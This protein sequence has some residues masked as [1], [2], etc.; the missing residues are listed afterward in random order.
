L[1]KSKNKSLNNGGEKP[2]IIAIGASAG[3]L[4]ALQDLLSNF[5]TPKKPFSVIIAQHVSP[6]HKSMLVQLLRRETNLEVEEATNGSE[7]KSGFVYITPPDNDISVTN[8]KIY[9]SKPANSVGPKPSVDIL[10]KSL[11]EQDAN[12]VIGIILSGTGTDGAHGVE[13]LKKAGAYILVQDPSTAKYDGMPATSIL[14]DSVDVILHPLKMGNAINR[15]ISNPEEARLALQADL[16]NIAGTQK[17]LWLLGKHTGTDFSNYKSA[18]INRRLQRRI[19]ILGLKD[20][21]E[22]TRYIDETPGELD[23]M[24]NSILIGVTTFFRD[25]DAFEALEEVL[26]KLLNSKPTTEPFRIWIPGC[27]TGEE[28][29]SIAIL[30]TKLTQNRPVQRDIQIFATDIDEKAIAKARKGIYSIDSV[31]ELSNEILD[32]YFIKQDE[33]FELQKSIRSMVL[34]SKHDLTSNPPFLKLDLITCRNLL[35]YFNTTLQQQVIPLFHYALNAE[36]YLLLGKSESIGHFNDLFVA[37]DSKVKLFQRK[38]GGSLNAVKFSGFKAVKQTVPRY[39]KKPKSDYTVADMVKETLFNT[40]EHPYVIIDEEGDIREISGDVRLFLSLSP[41]SIQVNLL[42]M[43]NKELQLELRSVVTTAIRKRETVRSSIRKFDLFGKEYFVRFHTK[44]LL[45]TKDSEILFMVIFERLDIDEFITKGV[46]QDTGEVIDSKVIELEHELATTKEHLQTYIEEIE[47]SNEE[48]QSLNEELQS[49]N[50]EF[51]STNEELETTNEELQSTNEEIQIAY[52]ELK[53]INEELERSE[54][55]LESRERNLKA[56][57]NNTLQAFV[58]IDD[59]YKVVLQNELA[60]Q[61]GKRLGVSQ[62]RPGLSVFDLASNSNMEK[63]IS[64]IKRA[65][66]GETIHDERKEVGP[67]GESIWLEYNLTP[68]FDSENKVVLVSLGLIDISE[69]K[70]FALKL[71]STEK[72]LHSVFDAAT[73]GICITDEKG[74][75]VDVNSEYCRIYGY[76]RGELIGHHFNMVVPPE[77]R[78]SLKELHDNFIAGASE[79]AAEWT[80]QRKDGSLIDIYASARLLVYEDGSRYKVTSVRDISE[81]KKYHNLLTET[82]ETAHV[83]GWEYDVFTKELTWTEEI[84]KIFEVSENSNADFEL[85]FNFFAFEAKSA[86]QEAVQVS[87]QKGDAF[88]LE[89]FGETSGGRPVWT[90]ITCKPIRVHNKT[91]KLFGTIQDVTSRKVND[92]QLFESEQKYRAAF[93]NSLL[94]F[95]VTNPDGTI[96]DANPA[97]CD[98]FGYSLDE[99]KALGR[100]GIIDGETPGLRSMLEDRLSH[101]KVRGELICIRKTGEK[102]PVEFTSALYKAADGQMHAT[103]LMHNISDR[104]NREQHLKLL[105]SVLTNTD[106]A[107]LITEA[108]PFSEPG[109]RIIYVNEAFTRMTGYTSDEV[110]GKTPRILQGPNTDKEALSKLSKALR[111]WESCE[112]ETINYKKNGEEFWINF[113][114]TPVA[115]EAGWYTH[116]FAIERDV[117]AQKNKEIERKLLSD[118]IVAMNTEGSLKESL[119]AALKCFTSIGEFELFEVWT[120]NRDSKHINLAARYG[121]TSAFKQFYEL[122]SEDIAMEFGQGLPGSVWKTRKMIYWD[123]ISQRKSFT[124]HKAAAKAGLK[125][126]YGFPLIQN[127]DVVGVL[128]LGLTEVV[129]EH[130]YYVPMLNEIAEH[131]A[132]EIRRKQLDEELERIFSFAPDVIC[133]AGMDGYFKKVNPAMAELLGYSID[134]LLDNPITYFV[135]PDDKDKTGEE[136]HAIGTGHGRSSFENRYLT[137]SGEVVWLAWT[138][139]ILF[140][141]GLIYSVA[142]NITDRKKADEKL[143][144]MNDKLEQRAYDLARSNAELEQ[145]A[146]VASHDLQEPLRMITSFLAQI[147]KK[148]NPL[149]DDKGRQYIHFAVDGAQRMRS[150]I[151]DLL[152]YS[153]VGRLDTEFV[154]FNMGEVVNEVIQLY[155]A[156]IGETGAKITYKNLPEVYAIKVTM[157]QLL[158]NLIGNAL[159]FRVPDRTPE[160]VISCQDHGKFW[161]FTVSDNGFGIE[162]E[163]LERIFVIFQRL[164]T[165]EQY[166]GSGMGLA[167]CRKIIDT[168]GGKIWAESEFGSGTTFHFTLPKE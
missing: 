75:Y 76:E 10:F 93:Q 167:I 164:H 118:I 25:A 85:F 156:L 32:T 59:T 15:Y 61:V 146:Y 138:T 26:E 109:P 113:R 128:L 89:L 65:F 16:D 124:R 119:E 8:G 152:E 11:A 147:E 13:E 19:S 72:L 31:S 12:H 155:K 37:V 100:G 82:Q 74:R 103:T 144:G 120:V 84:F 163:H 67:N 98:M 161:E 24:F 115:N 149:L 80:V 81:N 97:A 73:L 70:E 3:G 131:F 71:N 55:R 44:P 160:I 14:T 28:A 52:S 43:V 22:Y 47:T 48:L 127:N 106:D 36:G 9:L 90:R 50:E 99:F 18:T 101:G 35:I 104:K 17:I 117:T 111:N 162:K 83:G 30:L 62:L 166:D 60:I 68:V 21:E 42:K 4:E 27:S 145:F 33:Y 125:S 69:A 5:K 126:A 92:A 20:V 142:K 122:S 96:L 87:L 78:T 46:I 151:L 143:R 153:R 108:E 168:H 53:S 56:L 39:D 51:Q 29:Y 158:Q 40:F 49:T 66:K 114:V 94:A 102:F 159:K 130:R 112:I 137:K 34:F 2:F 77:N 105:E 79:L 95:F 110:I 150:I 88:D 58:L 63:F 134:E 148:Y 54:L 6:T 64:E 129:K 135:H 140:E 121:S 123:D 154:Y 133:V 41:G 139:T 86:L 91:I 116:W 7:I 132:A 141:E 107:V 136:I 165:R 57:L 38:R 157:R 1:S 23:E 45:Y